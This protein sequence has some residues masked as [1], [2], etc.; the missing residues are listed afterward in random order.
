MVDLR[1]WSILKTDTPPKRPVL[2]CPRLVQ[3]HGFRS[4]KVL[5]FDTPS[6]SPKNCPEA[7]ED[8]VR[9]QIS[10]SR[11]VSFFMIKPRFCPSRDQ[12]NPV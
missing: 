11:P 7:K 9:V 2:Y 3:F 8:Y 10:P 5:K 1:V 6:A 4:V 12:F